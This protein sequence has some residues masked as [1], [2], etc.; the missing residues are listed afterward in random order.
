MASIE[1]HFTNF[2][3]LKMTL[4]DIED[5]L[6]QE[7]RFINDGVDKAAVIFQN[8]YMGM[9]YNTNEGL[10]YNS[11]DD[12]TRKNTFLYYFEH[13]LLLSVQ[14]SR[15]GNVYQLY[16]LEPKFRVVYK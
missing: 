9:I 10:F 11:Q 5:A 3:D 13:K 14:Y 16:R 8:T 2:M 12:S 4:H 7:I 15:M 1:K 6:P